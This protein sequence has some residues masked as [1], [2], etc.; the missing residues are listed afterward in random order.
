[1][2]SFLTLKMFVLQNRTNITRVEQ[3]HHVLGVDVI[4]TFDDESSVHLRFKD[5]DTAAMTYDQLHRYVP[6]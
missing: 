2:M 1:M 3:V 5:T 4:V 6:A